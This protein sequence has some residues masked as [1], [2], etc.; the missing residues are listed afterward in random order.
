MILFKC[1]KCGAVIDAQ[2]EY[3]GCQAACTYCGAEQEIPAATDPS[4][5]LVFTESS[6]AT[7]TPMTAAE[8]HVRIEEGTVRPS[9]L[10]WSDGMWQP[11]D[12]VF[13]L[14]ER[15]DESALR[16]DVPEL[17]T[18]FEELA[19]LGG[20]EKLPRLRRR[21]GRVGVAAIKAAEGAPTGRAGRLRRHAKT[22]LAV[23]VLLIGAFCALKVVNVSMGRTAT[24][25]VRNDTA[26]RVSVSLP[27][28]KKADIAPGGSAVAAEIAVAVKGGGRLSWTAAAEGASRE[29]V[30]I[31]LAPKCVTVVG[32]GEAQFPLLAADFDPAALGEVAQEA[33]QAFRQQ[34]A[35]AEMPQAV[36]ALCTRAD[37]CLKDAL[38]EYSPLHCFTEKECRLDL[39]LASASSGVRPFKPAVDGDRRQILLPP[40]GSTFA[41]QDDKFVFSAE[42]KLASASVAVKGVAVA[43]PGDFKI[44]GDGVLSL[45]RSLRNDI[46]AF[47][48]MNAPV[49]LSLDG[50]EFNGRWCLEAHCVS[51]NWRCE[52]R[53][54]PRA[55]V[56]DKP[57][58]VAAPGQRPRLP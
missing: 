8:L 47:L 18:A 29:T 1:A 32:L 21:K 23:I 17:A 54:L 16:E 40:T 35:A 20:A 44:G 13:E 4:C 30:N 5:V 10:I 12:A 49:K 52:W 26:D 53:L 33:C 38:V 48:L 39:Y 34:L 36:A 14:P 56:K 45:T 6:P 7:G 50:K 25:V 31:T 27:G 37:Q 11:L 9:D 58:V 22:A 3:A 42:L 57:L 28:G 24:L 15:P 55:D 46:D 51:G 19:P 41:V 2:D 43:L